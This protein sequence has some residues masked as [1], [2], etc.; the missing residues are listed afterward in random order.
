MSSPRL[1]LCMIVKNEE[2][3]LPRCLASVAEI[4]DEMIIVDTGST[5]RTKEIASSFGAKVFDYEWQG[6]F[7]AA[8]NFSLSKATGDWIL[9]MDGDDEL[10]P[11]AKGKI[12]DLLHVGQEIQ[13]YRMPVISFLGESPGGPCSTV[14]HVRIFRNLP[15]Y[16]YTGALHEQLPMEIYARCPETPYKIYHYGYLSRI[17]EKKDKTNRNLVLAEQE[18]A[19]EPQSLFKQYNLGAELVRAGNFTRGAKLLK[20]VTDEVTGW[21]AYAPSAFQKLALCYVEQ[22]KLNAALSTAKRGWQ[23]CPWD[24]SLLYLQGVILMAKGKTLAAVKIFEECLALND[25]VRSIVYQGAGDSLA[26]GSLSSAFVQLGRPWAAFECAAEAYRI[27]SNYS[28][29]LQA[30]IA[31]LWQ[32]ADRNEARYYLTERRIMPEHIA[33]RLLASWPDNQVGK[34]II[35]PFSKKPLISLCLITKNEADNLRNHL[36]RLTAIADEII[37]V[38]TGST[39]DTVRVAEKFGATVTT[40]TWN[41]NFSLARNKALSLARGK[42]ILSIDAD[43]DISLSDCG[44]IRRIAETGKA[45]AYRF[46]VLNHLGGNAPAMRDK[47]ILLFRNRK[48]FKYTGA[49]YEQLLLKKNGK[50][51]VRVED[52]DVQVHHHGFNRDLAGFQAK[53]ERNIKILQ[54]EI[55]KG[56]GPYL[57]YC[58][59]SEYMQTNRYREALAELTKTEKLCSTKEPYY[60]DIIRKIALCLFKLKDYSGAKR[61]IKAGLKKL[62]SALQDQYS[63]LSSIYLIQKQY[64]K[65]EK[66][67]QKLFQTPSNAATFNYAWELNREQSY[68]DLAQL[69]LEKDK[70]AEAIVLCLQVLYRTPDFV[71]AANLL[72]KIL[73]QRSRPKNVEIFLERYFNLKSNEGLV[74][75][76]AQFIA[77]GWPGLSLKLLNRIDPAWADREPTVLK[78]KLKAYTSMLKNVLTR[79]RESYPG[80]QNLRRAWSMWER[81]QKTNT[82]WFNNSV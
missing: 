59:A 78:L 32:V 51:P 7:A 30:V 1:S 66:I 16:R 71:P 82:E 29:A 74:S 36:G 8:R 31:Y 12:R 3:F 4:V 67:L 37:V 57:A 45:D 68:V 46:T 49:V 76:A 20:A 80:D 43:I 50:K 38:D 65:A 27:N 70:W 35:V 6:D 9:I 44:K 53:R 23:K 61:V 73:K 42:W 60:P 81:W 13:G 48:N 14:H 2:E 72:S 33:D 24:L 21:E 26:L 19:A 11:E 10:A 28:F 77:L 39:D 79:A 58:L 64:N 75:L 47:K 52:S 62:G 41:D 18:L 34:N 69:Y 55:N 54:K 5:D 63:L 56:A 40:M 22:K 15:K 17:V 25:R